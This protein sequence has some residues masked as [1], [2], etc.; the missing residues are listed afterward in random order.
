MGKKNASDPLEEARQAYR[1]FLN[2]HKDMQAMLKW[3]NPDEGKLRDGLYNLISQYAGIG[4]L[5]SIL[6]PRQR[7]FI[8]GCRKRVAALTLERVRRINPAIQTEA[9]LLDEAIPCVVK[10]KRV[11]QAT[12]KGSVV[13]AEQGQRQQ[14]QSGEGQGE[15]G[16]TIPEQN[17]GATTAGASDRPPAEDSPSF[18]GFNTP[19]QQGATSKG[20]SSDTASKKTGRKKNKTT[21]KSTSQGN[22][23]AADTVRNNNVNAISA[24]SAQNPAVGTASTVVDSSNANSNLTPEQAERM[25][26][27]TAQAMQLQTAANN[28]QVL[29]NSISQAFLQATGSPIRMP[30]GAP[31]MEASTPGPGV[32]LPT[33]TQS[34]SA[35]P[36][37]GATPPAL[38][39]LN[40]TTLLMA[41]KA[42]RRS[43]RVMQ[44]TALDPERNNGPH[45]DLESAVDTDVGEDNDGTLG[46]DE[47]ETEEEDSFTDATSAGEEG[48]LIE[49]EVIHHGANDQAAAPPV[50]STGPDN[51]AP[52]MVPTGSSVRSATDTP[53]PPRLGPHTPWT[54]GFPP[55][56]LPPPGLSLS[57]PGSMYGNLL[58]GYTASQPLPLHGSMVPGLNTTLGVPMIPLIRGVAVNGVTASSIGQPYATDPLALNNLLVNSMQAAGT[59]GSAGGGMQVNLSSAGSGAAAL[60]EGGASASN[61]VEADVLIR[62]TP[63]HSTPQQASQPQP[64]Q[65]TTSHAAVTSVTASAAG[66]ASAAPAAATSRPSTSR[67]DN[68]I[69]SASG[70]GSKARSAQTSTSTALAP[71]TA[72]EHVDSVGGAIVGVDDIGLADPAPVSTS[73]GPPASSTTPAATYASVVKSTAAPTSYRGRYV[74][75]G[76]KS[77]TYS[78]ASTAVAWSN[79]Q[80]S[81][82][83]PGVVSS[84][85][86]SG[87]RMFT[88]ADFLAVTPDAELQDNGNGVLTIVPNSQS[89]AG[90]IS[91][92]DHSTAPT[93]TKE[94]TALDDDGGE[95]KKK[96]KKRRRKRREEDTEA[97]YASAAEQA[98][99]VNSKRNAG[100]PTSQATGAGRSGT[101]GRG[102][103]QNNRGGHRRDDQKDGKPGSNVP[104][105]G[106]GGG[107]HGGGGDD[108]P[109]P[110][111]DHISKDKPSKRKEHKKKK[112]RDR[113]GK[114][115]KRRHRSHSGSSRSSSGSSSSSDSSSSYDSESSGSSRSRRRSN[116]SG[117]KGS[118]CAAR[119]DWKARGGGASAQT[120]TF[121]PGWEL[122][123]D[124]EFRKRFSKCNYNE[125][126]KRIAARPFIGTREDYVRWQ[127]LF[128]LDIHIQPTR[129]IQAKCEALDMCVTPDV[130]EEIFTNLHF[131]ADDYVERIERLV[132]NYGGVDA[133]QDTLIARLKSLTELK[134]ESV[135]SLRRYTYGLGAYLKNATK[136]EAESRLLQSTLKENLS[137][138]WRADFNE[139]VTKGRYKDS[140][141]D[142]YQ[143]LLV[144]LKARTRTE[145][146]KQAFLNG[147]GGKSNGA[148]NSFHTTIE[149]PA[150][151]PEAIEL[152][153][154]HRA[155]QAHR[156]GINCD[157][158]EGSHSVYNCVKFY[159]LISAEERK[160][161]VKEYGGCY[162]CLRRGH[163]AAEC[164]WLKRNPKPCNYCHHPHNRMLHPNGSQTGT[165]L[166]PAP[167]VGKA[168]I[169]VQQQE[170]DTSH[171]M[172]DGGDNGE[173]DGGAVDNK[174]GLTEPKE[175]AKEE[176]SEST[177]DNVQTLTDRDVKSEFI[178]CQST[179]DKQIIPV[180]SLAPNVTITIVPLYVE[181]GN[182]RLLINV[183]VDTGANTSAMSSRLAQ[184]LGY[185]P[186]RY[187]KHRVKVGG[188][189]VNEYVSADGRIT[190]E[191]PQTKYRREINV[192]CY[193]NPIGNAVVPNWS[194]L[195]NNWAHLKDL[196]IPPPV[197][198]KGIDLFLGNENIDL[199]TA[200]EKG[201]MGGPGEPTAT[202]TRLGWIVGGRTH[203]PDQM[204]TQAQFSY[205]VQTVCG[206]VQTQDDPVSQMNADGNGD[207][208]LR[209][210]W[211]KQNHMTLGEKQGT[212]VTGEDGDEP[213]LSFDV[214]QKLW[215]QQNGA[216]S[217]QFKGIVC[218]NWSSFNTKS[219]QF[220]NF[221]SSAMGGDKKT[222]PLQVF[223]QSKDT[224]EQANKKKE[225]RKRLK[226]QFLPDDSFECLELGESNTWKLK[227]EEVRH[228]IGRLFEIE[229]AEEQRKLRNQVSKMPLKVTEQKALDLFEKSVVYEKRSYTVGLIWKND[230]ARPRNNYVEALS[231]YRKQEQRMAKDPELRKHYDE[232]IQSWIKEGYVVPVEAKARDEGH[233]L[234]HFMVVRTD[235]ATTKYRLVVHGAFEFEGKSINDFLL[236]GPNRIQKIQQVLHKFRR[237][238]YVLGA[239]VEAMFMRIKVKE[240][241]RKYIRIFYRPPG[242][243]KLMVLEATRHLFGLRSSPFVACQTVLH[244]ATR[245]K[246]KWPAAFRAISQHMMVDD[247]LISHDSLQY[248][249]QVRD[250]CQEL[251][252]EMGMKLHKIMSNDKALLKDL[253]AEQIAKNFIVAET[254]EGLG[255]TLGTTKA[256]GLVW[257]AEAD[258]LTF[259]TDLD[260]QTRWTLRELVSVAARVFDPQGLAAPA[261]I[262]GKILTQEAWKSKPKGWDEELPEP[263][264]RKISQWVRNLKDLDKFQVPRSLVSGAEQCEKRHLV[265]FSDASREAMGACVFLRSV[266][267]NG[268]IEVALVAAKAR[269]TPIRKPESIP[270]LETQ[271]AVLGTELCAEIAYSL[272]LDRNEVYYFVDS[273]TVIWWIISGRDLGIFVANRICI[274]LE[275]A[276]ICQWRWVA[277]KLNPADLPSRGI[278][279]EDLV[280]NDLWIKGPGWLSLPEEQWPE[281]PP[282][283]QTLEAI[284]EQRKVE[285]IAFFNQLDLPV[286]VQSEQLQLWMRQQLGRFSSAWRGLR[287][288]T[289][290]FRFIRMT[291]PT[292][293]TE[294]QRQ[295]NAVQRD[296]LLELIKQDQKHYFPNTYKRLMT[297]EQDMEVLVE[298]GK[299]DTLMSLKPYIDEAGMLRAY[300]RL[301]ESRYL[302]SAMV[303]PLLLPAESPMAAFISELYHSAPIYLNHTGGI[304]CLLGR[305]RE[306]VW[307]LRARKVASK[308]LKE[309]QKCQRSKPVQIYRSPP[310]LNWTRMGKD[311]HWR[312]FQCCGIDMGGPFLVR[313]GR[314]EVKR[315]L[316]LISCNISRAVNLEVVYDAGA[317][318][319]GK[320]ITRHE[321]VYGPLEAVNSDNGGNLVR[322]HNQI[323]E[324][325]QLHRD[326]VGYLKDRFPRLTWMHN[327]ALSARWGGHFES[328]IGVAKKTMKE[329]TG[330][331]YSIMDDED[332][333]TLFKMVQGFM[334]ERPLIRVSADINDGP[335]IT[336]SQFMLTGRPVLGQPPMLEGVGYDYREMR[337]ALDDAQVRIRNRMVTEIF[338]K[339]GELPRGKE[340][341][342]EPVAV[343]DIVLMLLKTGWEKKYALGRVCKVHPGVDGRV[344]SVDIEH[345][346]PKEGVGRHTLPG[347]LVEKGR[348]L[349]GFVKMKIFDAPLPERY[350]LP[351]VENGYELEEDKVATLQH[352]QVFQSFI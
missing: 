270:R 202:M 224:A 28:A 296:I 187:V 278:K 121:P 210:E 138:G 80:T 311:P 312:P 46:D 16:R 146:E 185:K 142:L 35:G 103:Q 260:N 15:E 108:S 243:D 33:S 239:D 134:D 95:R 57:A 145:E 149:L 336:P 189:L 237:G 324:L 98:D 289:F 227:Y 251:F 38:V 135:S 250:E 125:A 291:R 55:P 349:D 235:K 199:F 288:L 253:P 165:G 249:R 99:G 183:L 81:P 68:D 71:A 232:V 131:T 242:E 193:P 190:I 315:Y 90:G 299:Q 191:S 173:P 47:D 102:G 269:V 106:G 124:R 248:L 209:L 56:R 176:T 77:T 330:Y 180:R 141:N 208:D 40:A 218:N 230:T 186:D 92:V 205:H 113:K 63:P 256:L 78:G 105:S 3:A 344:R 175:K 238:R 319:L 64:M 328:L 207:E 169:T 101:A 6:S 225:K 5:R 234:V 300:T 177:N 42:V 168:E 8:D 285:N 179:D 139:E 166:S 120:L 7:D 213:E 240:A 216:S 276:D 83:T 217:S 204:P 94:D 301:Q 155:E 30:G 244:H 282:V 122:P 247:V 89:R 162:T 331:P 236:P 18:R 334:N 342:E 66:G 283:R 306:F 160:K 317:P 274:L 109:P 84:Q 226:H 126:L 262:T 228:Q 197:A 24:G 44:R 335:P 266:Y 316:I 327:P 310:P 171:H 223:M 156:R 49:E 181:V 130:R 143:W 10:P 268:V 298:Y 39:D 246:D 11:R 287:F 212:D 150:D 62:E 87:R 158:C 132:H 53:F 221:A 267:P 60:A 341:H 93:H 82:S 152:Q 279:A 337:K 211:E 220:L 261:L 31:A 72:P 17:G 23:A 272:G 215:E 91:E 161:A 245:N 257:E 58:N 201:I 295:M 41:P 67:G 326:H 26:V 275:A 281:Q 163:T 302:D 118:K 188:G 286:V 290:V 36:G 320:A 340:K 307:I 86:A 323:A 79:G 61:P 345:Y 22:E 277:T 112:K 338:T 117:F 352:A 157:Y 347:R 70:R 195:K 48:D 12:T 129:S 115:K 37:S 292:Q 192:H 259:I 294:E 14:G 309:C 164:E 119:V 332:L 321:A 325:R 73:A 350:Q 339:L 9:H 137:D 97:E 203:R 198:G 54:P 50:M 147:K 219:Q 128:Y 148:R 59:P 214:G 170:G 100:P 140:A 74:V 263:L 271:A 255:E 322:I 305:L 297:A 314:S 304:E 4:S 280:D 110:S 182:K 229:T 104:R 318:S 174:P 222:D 284:A 127:P 348:T 231:L 153:M 329:L 144:L 27:L 184:L 206:F 159:Q 43:S 308:T 196:E 45:D 178:T 88:L 20:Q 96:R 264:C 111:D 303:K 123:S 2:I 200:I 76:S 167:I 233:Y 21:P 313:R 51:L 273:T 75:R 293:Y 351:L 346:L 13:A 343:G 252:E 32:I 1:E 133:L 241:D 107:G 25:Q 114:K 194:V 34:Q 19:E 154:F 65:S 69:R 29:L 136:G 265:T 172:H 333:H 116:G 258:Q 254:E 85:S 151:S 52:T